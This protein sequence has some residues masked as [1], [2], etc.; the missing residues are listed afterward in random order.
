VAGRHRAPC[1]RVEHLAVGNSPE[2]AAR[3]RLIVLGAN[4][5]LRP[6][7]IEYTLPPGRP[8][9]GAARQAAR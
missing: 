9:T 2:M 6:S 3:R 8:R 7:R 4:P 1:A 5:A